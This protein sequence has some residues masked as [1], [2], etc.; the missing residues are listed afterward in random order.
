MRR[1]TTGVADARPS[2]LR[3][4]WAFGLLAVLLACLWLAGGASKMDDY[5]QPVVRAAAWGVLII[6]LVLGPRPDRTVL[7][8][9][10]LLAGGVLLIVIWQLVPL[11]PD[12]WS[13][14]SGRQPFLAAGSEAQPWRPLALVPGAAINAV[15][16]L[17][18]PVAVLLLALAATAAERA[19]LLDILLAMIA[20]SA[21]IAAFQFTRPSQFGSVSGLFANRNHFAVFVAIGCLLTPV[22]VYSVNSGSRWRPLAGSGLILF[23]SLIVLGTGSRSGALLTPVA[24][25][26]G[27]VTVRGRL[28]AQLAGRSRVTVALILGAGICAVGALVLASVWA[29]RAVS[30]DRALSLAAENEI[31]GRALPT[32]MMMVDHYFSAGSG[33]GGFATIF[34]VHEPDALLKPTYFNQAHNDLLGVVLDAGL[35]GGAMLAAAF[36]WWVWRSLGAWRSKPNNAVRLARAGSAVLLLLGVASLVDYPV[37]TPIMMAL[38]VIGALWL[39]GA[40][41]CGEGAALPRHTH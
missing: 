22:W 40:R 13:A 10:T 7:R 26:I 37:R 9:A 38:A 28:R 35:V 32:V 2:W 8:P 31:R 29:G 6:A 1:G 12:I 4:S 33:L 5:G 14:L 17:I 19:R 23:F 11:P 20:L 18:V 34:K 15:G 21:V 16:S 27:L 3:L 41:A 39:E 36:V 24:I 25:V 30:I